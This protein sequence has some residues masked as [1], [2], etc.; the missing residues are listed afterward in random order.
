MLR[1]AAKHTRPPSLNLRAPTILLLSRAR[2]SVRAGSNSA[3]ADVS[4]NRVSRLRFAT[5]SADMRCFVRENPG[6]VFAD[7]VRWY[8]PRNWQGGSAHPHDG[9]GLE[10]ADGGVNADF[11]SSASDVK[12]AMRALVA[13]IVERATA[14]EVGV[15]P[16]ATTAAAYAPAVAP[17]DEGAIRADGTRT[18]RSRG[19]TDTTEELTM[20]P[21]T[22]LTSVGGAEAETEAERIPRPWSP[23]P[24]NRS[25]PPTASDVSP[26]GW[27]T[28]I[29]G[30]N[31]VSPN[32]SAA[33]A[34]PDAAAAVV[35]GV[36]T[37][38]GHSG[39]VPGGEGSR[40]PEFDGAS[41]TSVDRGEGGVGI[42]KR[43]GLSPS[44]LLF[45]SLPSTIPSLLASP[46]C[47]RRLDWGRRGKVE[48]R[49]TA[50]TAAAATATAAADDDVLY[51]VDEKEG[52]EWMHAWLEVENTVAKENEGGV[53]RPRNLFNPAQVS[54][55][56]L[57]YSAQSGGV[58][59]QRLAR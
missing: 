48:W 14:Y 39:G 11:F 25:N 4:R 18:L 33:G 1:P 53:C 28:I 35:G 16:C 32:A 56:W 5:L 2:S 17:A 58:C 21:V 8:S 3:D 43:S 7:F 59:G 30:R 46:P 44:S 12:D 38:D 22:T 36:A 27:K 45:S 49:P 26:S 9:A 47:P 50:E 23:P 57:G 42:G 29:P 41:C 15:L 20:P 6:A 19:E 31:I 52:A 51:G 37:S 10:A 13:D 54:S 24:A 34:A 40:S 55:W